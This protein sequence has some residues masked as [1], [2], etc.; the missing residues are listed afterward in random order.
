MTEPSPAPPIRSSRRQKPPRGPVLGLLLFLILAAA[1]VG[2]YLLS[3]P[4]LEF[5]NRLAAPVRLAIDT[6]EAVVVPAGQSQR[7]TVARGKTL[8]AL[9]ELVRPLSANGRPMGEEVRG[10]VVEPNMKGT[11]RGSAAPRGASG[12]HFAP[13]ISNA[14]SDLLRI[15]VNAGLEGAVDCGCAVRPGARRVFIGYYR[16]YGNST[17]QARS[18]DGRIA[19][20]QGLGPNVVAQDGAL[21][22]RFESKDLS[23]PPTAR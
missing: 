22:L 15:T 18:S 7:L 20:F 10:S 16:L 6:R 14:T 1:G 13:L 19:M 9:W 4:K 3:R 21:G 8:V 12:D 2:Y 5:T 11:M 23:R 17:V